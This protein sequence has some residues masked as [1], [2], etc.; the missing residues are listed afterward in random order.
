MKGW[1]CNPEIDRDYT[2]EKPKNIVSSKVNPG[3]M[4]KLPKAGRDTFGTGQW[5]M[6]QTKRPPDTVP[7]CPG[8]G[9]RDYFK[10]KKLRLSYKK[11][12]LVS[13]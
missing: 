1:S 3:D 6:C 13:R 4:V 8:V 10:T 11:A 12:G 7:F 2:D 9:L 5:K